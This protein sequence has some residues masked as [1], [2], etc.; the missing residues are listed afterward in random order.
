MTTISRTLQ[1]SGRMRDTAWEQLSNTLRTG[2]DLCWYELSQG[3]KLY[4][5]LLD[6]G[7]G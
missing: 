4:S 2:P 6:S 1:P 3:L 7:H 5:F